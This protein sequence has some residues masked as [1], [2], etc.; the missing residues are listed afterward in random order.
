MDFKLYDE[1]SKLHSQNS[2]ITVPPLE[3]FERPLRTFLDILYTV[4]ALLALILNCIAFII[5][6]RAKKTA[7]Q[8]KRYLANLAI[9][10]LVLGVF[11]VPFTYI[12]FMYGIWPF[13]LW[14]CPVWC[15]VNV[16]V[17]FAN[18]YLLIAIGFGRY[19]LFLHKF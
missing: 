12:D 3:A 4:T 10:D 2:S 16:W 15:V 6:F 11:N 5:I 7:K 14:L 18:I 8:L 19:A 17:T 9:T 1:A 13:P